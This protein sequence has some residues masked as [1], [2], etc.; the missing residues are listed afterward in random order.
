MP[1]SDPQY[2][3]LFDSMALS[4]AHTFENLW[5]EQGLAMPVGLA[6]TWGRVIV[7]FLR[8]RKDEPLGYHIGMTRVRELVDAA[9]KESPAGTEGPAFLNTFARLLRAELDS[10]DEPDPAASA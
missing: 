8:S 7:E 9:E 2:D 3:P 1:L 6:E 10:Y 5:R 4:S